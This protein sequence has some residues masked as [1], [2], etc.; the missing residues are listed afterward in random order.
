MLYVC[1]LHT[2][3]DEAAGAEEVAEGV[4]ERRRGRIGGRSRQMTRLW[5]RQDQYELYTECQCNSVGIAFI[6]VNS[7]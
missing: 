1:M 7:G 2:N 5:M 3:R 4:V 6:S